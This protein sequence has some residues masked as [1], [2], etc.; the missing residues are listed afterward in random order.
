VLGAAFVIGAIAPTP[1][2]WVANYLSEAGVPAHPYDAP[3]RVGMLTLGAG[4]LVLAG[5]VGAA[6]GRPARLAVALLG[7]AGAAVALSGTVT[8]SAGCPL[9]PYETPTP[10]DWVHA[11]AAVAGVGG[12]GLAIL[13]LGYGA[14]TSAGPGAAGPGAAGPGAAGPGAALRRV[15]RIAAGLVVPGGVATGLAILLVG[16]GL[17]TGLLERVTVA[18]ALAWTL[19]AAW[20]LHRRPPSPDPASPDQPSP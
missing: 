19:A 4:L 5:A 18:G 9:P 12:I 15:S 16:R 3:Y 6:L 20:A 11:V 13:V 17:V 1:A 14:G 8:C 2:L 10:A 7:A